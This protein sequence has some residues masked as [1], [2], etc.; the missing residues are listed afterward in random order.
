MLGP[1]LITGAKDVIRTQVLTALVLAS[2]LVTVGG[3]AVA[4]Q[5]DQTRTDSQDFRIVAVTPGPSASAVHGL[6]RMMDR[7]RQSDSVG[8]FGKPAISLAAALR[9]AEWRREVSDEL[10][11]YFR[12]RAQRR[13][14]QM[15]F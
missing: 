2:V 5:S 14:L 9:M 12:T 1:S 10:S 7:S 4:E 8:D 15:K 6:E 13:S 11:Q 3:P